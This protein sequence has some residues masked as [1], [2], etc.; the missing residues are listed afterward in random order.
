MPNSSVIDVV[1][2]NSSEDGNNDK[3]GTESPHAVSKANGLIRVEIVPFE[4]WHSKFFLGG[5]HI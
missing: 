5:S 4:S 1:D 3:G 2:Y